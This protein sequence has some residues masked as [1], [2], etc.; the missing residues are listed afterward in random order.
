MFA[1]EEFYPTLRLIRDLPDDVFDMLEICLLLLISLALGCLTLPFCRSDWTQ[2]VDVM[3]GRRC[4]CHGAM[5]KRPPLHR[6]KAGPLALVR[7]G[8][9]AL[10]QDHWRP[11]GRCGLTLCRPGGWIPALS[12]LPTR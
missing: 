1:F 3:F 11:R 6:G 2:L 10:F 4:R 8:G 7:A 9:A 5:P 12:W